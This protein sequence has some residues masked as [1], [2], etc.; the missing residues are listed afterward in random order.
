MVRLYRCMC[1]VPVQVTDVGRLGILSR[2]VRNG[3][4]RK[5]L[6]SLMLG[7]AK[8][9]GSPAKTDKTLTPD[10]V[11]GPPNGSFS[12]PEDIEV[13]NNIA[14]DDQGGIYVV[15]SKYMHKAEWDGERLTVIWEEPYDLEPGL[16]GTAPVR[17]GEGSGSTPTL[18]GTASRRYV[19]ITDSAKLM[20]LVVM[21]ARTGKVE[22]RHPITFGDPTAKETTSEQ[23]VLVHGWR[24]AVVNNQP[25]EETRVSTNFLH[26]LGSPTTF[27]A[28]LSSSGSA[29]S[30][31]ND[32]VAAA[33]PVIVGDA[34]KGVEQFEYDPDTKKIRSV[35]VNKDVSIPNGIPS[36]SAK[37]QLMYG[38]GKRCPLGGEAA[39]LRGMW[40]LEALDWWT[41]VSK[42]HYNIG[43]GPMSNSVYAATQI[44]PNEIITGTAGGIVRI[45]EAL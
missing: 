32:T 21:D 43:V 7:A 15:S 17:L 26:Y 28:G 6:A 4:F 3:G 19:V 14:C 45:R 23:S 41:G 22:A 37:S 33:F 18:M 39:P 29:L 27:L 1:I 44:G 25:T 16:G 35:W 2:D 5:A 8:R 9:E 42:F 24:M 36:M 34:P 40:T 11:S 38:V 31:L 12:A 10:G 20:N 13:S 30:R